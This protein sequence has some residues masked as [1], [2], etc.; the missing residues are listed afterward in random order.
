MECK[1]KLINK[2]WENEKISYFGLD[3]GPFTQNLGPIFS[4]NFLLLVV[5]IVPSYYP[6]QFKEKLLSHTWEN[7]EKHNFGPNFDPFGQNVGPRFFP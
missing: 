5:N 2:I 7:G 1:R 6:M 4:L 3:F